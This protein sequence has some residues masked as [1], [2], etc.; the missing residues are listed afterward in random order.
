MKPH[1]K[2]HHSA[3]FRGWQC[4]TLFER[5]YGDTPKAA[6]DAWVRQING[7]RST[8]PFEGGNSF[9]HRPFR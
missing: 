6:Y 1:I 5:G 2:I 7:L 9:F 4:G 8:R 3:N